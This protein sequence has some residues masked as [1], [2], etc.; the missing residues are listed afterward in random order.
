MNVVYTKCGAEL[1]T[2]VLHCPQ[3]RFY[4]N[5]LFVGGV[6]ESTHDSDIDE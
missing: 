1:F 2:S 6:E 4:N 5:L 3:H